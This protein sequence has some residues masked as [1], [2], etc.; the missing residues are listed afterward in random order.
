MTYTVQ[1]EEFNGSLEK[2]LELIEGKKLDIT[3]VSLAAV[4]NDFIKYVES[5]GQK[6]T[7]ILADFIGIAAKL[8]LI[9]SKSLIPTFEFTAREQE[10][11]AELQKKLETYQRVRNMTG[12][13]RSIWNKNEIYYARTLLQGL[14]ALVRPEIKI[15]L[16]D[17]VVAMRKLWRATE[18]TIYEK[19]NIKN[20]E[21]LEQTIERVIARIRAGAGKNFNALHDGKN[22]TEI[23]IIFIALLHL[24]KLGSIRIAQ[25]S[26]FDDMIIEHG[27]E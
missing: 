25:Q 17:F 12:M 16:A 5:L 8:M 11:I 7:Q 3:T 26:A 23:I 15:S 13:L 20:V 6:D 1:T 14:D 19:G 22:R 18:R 2:L 10:D 9:K 4:T 27:E 21:T 24:A